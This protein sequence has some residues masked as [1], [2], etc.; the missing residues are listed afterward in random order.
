MTRNPVTKP[1]HDATWSRP[2]GNLDF[3][4]V[5][6]FGDM[7]EPQYGPHNGIDLGDT[8]C[9]STVVASAGG[10][11]DYAAA[12]PASGGAN[13][14]IVRHPNGER[15]WYAH[16]ASISVKPGAVIAAG[17]KLGTVGATGWAIGCHLHYQRQRRN[18]AGAWQDVDPLPLLTLVEQP[19]LPDS[20]TAG[21]EMDLAPYVTKAFSPP[22]R[23][24]FAAGTHTGY[25][26][27]GTPKAATPRAA[28]GA[29][30]QL[31]G[32][33]ATRRRAGSAAD[34]PTSPTA[35]GPATTCRSGR[36]GQSR[37]RQAT[38]RRSRTR[39]H[40]LRP[41]SI[42]PCRRCAPRSPHSA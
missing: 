25:K 26:P 1:I 40:G 30:R 16:L 19:L 17:Q 11:V 14:V 18:S 5:R 41:P 22:V 38:A 7:S 2:R 29:A 31:R 20:S 12:D 35:S 34:S 28:S 9:G 3:R 15:T 24:Q 6:L 4:I 13:I 42:A 8:L 37:R 32:R 36:A 27:D 23:M 39:S 21:E 10:V 33:L